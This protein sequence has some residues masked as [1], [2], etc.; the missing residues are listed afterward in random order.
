MNS[1]LK[2]SRHFLKLEP[3]KYSNRAISIYPHLKLKEIYE[4]QNGKELLIEGVHI[5]SPRSKYSLKMEDANKCSL[6]ALDLEVKHTDVLILSQYVRN[7]GCMLPRRVTG[8]CGKQQ[9]RVSSLVTMAQKA[10]LMSNLNPA[11]SNK[12]PKKRNGYKKYN[13]YFDEST[14]KKY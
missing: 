6:C 7:D 2:L 9:R 10:G 12:D 4:T 8:L 5:E 11:N 1:I 3:I 13:K 14:L